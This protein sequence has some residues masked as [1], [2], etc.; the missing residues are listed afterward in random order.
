MPNYLV[1]GVDTSTKATTTLATNVP[2]V[3][4]TG[5]MIRVKCVQMVDRN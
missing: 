5:L 4:N 2:L 3:S 1:P